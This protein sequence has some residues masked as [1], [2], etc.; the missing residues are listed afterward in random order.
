MNRIELV[1]LFTALEVL[2]DEKNI[3]GMGKIIKAVLKEAQSAAKNEAANR[4]D[5]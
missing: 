5:D 3:E 4:R 2:Y 1:A